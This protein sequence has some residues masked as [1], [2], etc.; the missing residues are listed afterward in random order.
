M[1]PV[2]YY[3]ICPAHIKI[4]SEFGTYQ[5]RAPTVKQCTVKS[6]IQIHNKPLPN[7]SQLSP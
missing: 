7:S 3:L 2:I 6:Y 1:L 4:Q 5:R